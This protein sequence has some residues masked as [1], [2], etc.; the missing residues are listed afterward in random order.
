[1]HQPM[2]RS[3]QQLSQQETAAMLDAATSGVLAVI[4]EDGCPYA[5]PLSFAREGDSLFFHS[6]TAGRKLD[7][8]AYCDRASFCVIAEDEVVQSTFTTHFRSAVVT[9][10][11]SVVTDD[12]RKRR[13][14]VRLA[15]KYSPDFLSEADGEIERSWN[16]L[17]VLELVIEEMSGKASIE[18]I[19]ERD[20]QAGEA[21]AE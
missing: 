20:R 5:V 8:I 13:A 14:L 18:I 4:G 12:Q 21:V 17:C 7:A 9:G 3:R 1:M 6:A 10:R 19:K 16:R 2:R 15:E 11:V